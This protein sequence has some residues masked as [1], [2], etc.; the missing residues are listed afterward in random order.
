MEEQWEFLRDGRRRW[1]WRYTSPEGTQR[2]S[3][4]AFASWPECLANARSHGYA[5]PDT[6]PQSGRDR[7]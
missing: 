3:S 1:Y 5:G 6:Q 7:E 4:Q 2:V